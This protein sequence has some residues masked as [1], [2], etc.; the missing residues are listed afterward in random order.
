M[1]RHS[2][3]AQAERNEAV[4]PS[5]FSGNVGYAEPS[6][7]IGEG[8]DRVTD[9]KLSLVVSTL[10]RSNELRVLLNSLERQELKAFEL[11]IVDQND[12]ERLAPVLQSFDWSFPITH[13]R[14]PDTRGVNRGRNE[15]WRRARGAYVLFPDDDCWY[16]PW[17]LSRGL[18]FTEQSGA[19]FV[20]GRAADESGR[21]ING[22]FGASAHRITRKNA[23]VSAIEWM[24]FFRRDS[25]ERLGGFDETI[26]PGSGSLWQANEGH[27]LIFRALRLGMLGFYDPGLF[28][29]HAELNIYTPDEAMIRKGRAYARGMGF[30]LRTSG[31]GPQWAAYWIMR[32][33]VNSGLALLRGNAPQF[34]YYSNLVIGRLEGYLKHTLPL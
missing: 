21:N 32:A 28:A 3:P 14:R 30:V 25:L 33:S 9:V 27:E 13:L 16:P 26:G 10:G 24:M 20:T 6:N 23:W 11:I 17:L 2:S 5:A 4:I 12:D 29:H 19:D 1:T 34:R 18:A 22:R 8:P 15:G 31:Y 7:D